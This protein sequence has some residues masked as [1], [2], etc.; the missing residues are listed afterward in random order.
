MPRTRPRLDMPDHLHAQRYRVIGTM[1]DSDEFAEALKC[2]AGDPMNPNDKCVF[3]Y[4]ALTSACKRSCDHRSGYYSFFLLVRGESICKCHIY[5]LQYSLEDGAFPLLGVA[6][7]ICQF[8][9]AQA[10]H[11]RETRVLWISRIS[12]QVLPISCFACL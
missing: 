11:T 12:W 4:R 7:S 8:L 6:E 1:R 9:M 10:P 2:K 3:W 5:W